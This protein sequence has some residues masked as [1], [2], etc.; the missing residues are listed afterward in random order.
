MLDLDRLIH[1]ALSED[2][3]LGDITSEAAV[4]ADAAARAELV[5]KED[6]VLA[7]LD[8]AARVFSFLDGSIAFERLTED[9]RRVQR[10]EVLVWLKGPARSLLS[11]ERTALNLLQRM[12]GIATL[13]AAFVEAVA[14]TGARIVDTRKTA[15]GLRAL[16]KYAVRVGGGYNHRIGLFDG[17]LLK[18]NHIAAAGGIA[19]AVARARQRAPHTLRIEVEVRNLEEVEQ[20]LAAG[21][22]ILLLDNMPP[23]L[24]RAAVALIGDRALTEASG[25]VSLET[26][27]EIA[28]TGVQLIS[29]GALTHSV[30]AA[31]ISLLFEGA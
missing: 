25:G 6:F 4:P 1:A 26:V 5:A 9:G 31:D 22:E 13:T 14:G 15:P 19:A 7:G 20:A 2:L 8:V 30:R 3:G 21:A 23:A 28:E 16:D 27:R 10:G 17:V 29:V 18:E 11:A 12:S 24:L